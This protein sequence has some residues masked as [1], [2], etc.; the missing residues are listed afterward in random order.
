MVK[1]N[2]RAD[3]IW[4]GLFALSLEKT[5]QSVT[6]FTPLNFNVVSSTV[7]NTGDTPLQ[8]LVNAT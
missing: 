5:G 6:I 3:D 2:L 4:W 1:H 7:F 8:F